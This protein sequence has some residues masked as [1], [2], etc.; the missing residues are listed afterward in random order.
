[1]AWLDAV[2]LVFLLASAYGGFRRGF[3]VGLLDLIGASAS[4]VGGLLGYAPLAGWLTANVA[5]LAP[6]VAD[7]AA[8]LGL[9]LAIQIVYGVVSGLIVRAMYPVLLAVPPMFWLDRGLGVV[10]GL[11][12]GAV[13][14][15]LLLLPFAVLPLSPAIGSAIEDSTLASRL[16]SLALLAAPE[17]ENRLGGDLASGLS[18][19]VLTPPQTAEEERG[20]PIQLGP[21]GTL[22]PDPAAEQQMLDLVN[23]ERVRTGLRPLEMDES[24]R[25]VARAHSQEMFQRG[26]F[27]HD[28]P[29]AGSP[30]DRMRAAGV[31]FFVAGENLAYAPTVQTAHDGLMHSPGHRANILRPEFAHVGIGIIHSQF[32]GSMFTQDFRN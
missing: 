16:V 24:L 6:A 9:A 10:P 31:T 30:Y 32:Q 23:Q 25:S 18:G 3:L 26:Y 12:R 29:T 11:A 17:V 5:G 7:V 15:S 21:L 27:A 4:I 13:F 20:G 19:L 28:S 22:T 1:V 2:V 14:V 8:I